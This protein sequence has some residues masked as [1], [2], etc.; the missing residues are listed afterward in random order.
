[1]LKK[2]FSYIFLF[3]IVS[4]VYSQNSTVDDKIGEIKDR[5]AFIDSLEIDYDTYHVV[6]ADGAVNFEEYTIEKG[7]IARLITG[8]RSFSDKTNTIKIYVYD[9]NENLCYYKESKFDESQANRSIGSAEYY[10]EEDIVLLFNQ[11]GVS[12][13]KGE[14]NNIER[15]IEES[16]KIKQSKADIINLGK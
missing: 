14:K 3:F 11:E 2:V 1:M 13:S 9:I 16:Q 4:V 7:R 12:L 8:N 15:I 6:Y 10:I 5:V